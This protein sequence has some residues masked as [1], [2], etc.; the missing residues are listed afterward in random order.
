ME[1]RQGLTSPGTK[2]NVRAA[3]LMGCITKQEAALAY[4]FPEV[5]TDLWRGIC[6]EG[7]VTEFLARL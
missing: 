1:L 5:A 3:F 4:L 7:R 2:R 6:Q